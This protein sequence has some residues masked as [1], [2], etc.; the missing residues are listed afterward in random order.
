MRLDSASWVLGVAWVL[1]LGVFAVHHAR[2]LSRTA[3]RRGAGMG[4]RRAPWAMAGM[5]VEG[6]ALFV[7]FT[8]RK[9][10]AVDMWF[11]AAVALMAWGIGLAWWAVRTLGDEW[12][13]KA[14]V[15]EDHK[16][17]TTGPFGLVRHPVYLS[18]FSM[19]LG[20][21]FLMCGNGRLALACA[22]YAVGTEIRVQAEEG[23]L[24]GRF[25]AEFEQYRKSVKAWLPPVR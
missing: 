22:I 1:Y 9:A 4:E 6:V 5:A 23:L 11:W 8:G 16:L 3:G 7:V 13:L 2:T 18:L 25:G 19:L 15:T 21:G 14:V 12:R 17:V 20:S 10:F 24:L